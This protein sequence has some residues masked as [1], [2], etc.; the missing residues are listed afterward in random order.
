[1]DL[2][3]LTSAELEAYSRSEYM[4]R[5]RLE[6]LEREL[7]KREH[8]TNQVALAEVKRRL[9][10][11]REPEAHKSQPLFAP[12][13]TNNPPKASIESRPPRIALLY[14]C[15]PLLWYVAFHRFAGNSAKLN[16]AKLIIAVLTPFALLSIPAF[17]FTMH[18]WAKSRVE[19]EPSETSFPR[20]V[21]VLTNGLA[22][23][24]IASIVI[25][26]VMNPMSGICRYD[27]SFCK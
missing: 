9:Q 17:F 7:L 4:G 19:A 21:L 22:L 12:S 14:L 11:H 27:E 6:D 16:A 24:V 2:S 1:M 26:S 18:E 13:D 8:G 15:I 5:E 10:P 3:R 20:I 23:I 25:Y